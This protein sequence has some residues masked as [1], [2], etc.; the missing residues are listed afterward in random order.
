MNAHSRYFPLTRH[1]RQATG[2]LQ[3]MSFDEV[4]RTIGRSLPPS[5]CGIHARQWWAN[6]ETHV[7]GKGWLDAGWK[8]EDIDPAKRQ[9]RFRRVRPEGMAEQGRAFEIASTS[10]ELV[11]AALRMIED[12]VEEKGGTRADAIVAILNQ[13]AI[14]RRRKTIE[15]FASRARPQTTNSVDLVREDRER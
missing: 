15:W 11:P 4:E 14:D 3:T 12:Y 9:V 8:V 13:A 5:A 1:L 2:D 6:T 7:Q 10:P